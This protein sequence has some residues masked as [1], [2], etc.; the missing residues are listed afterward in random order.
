MTSWSSKTKPTPGNIRHRVEAGQSAINGAMDLVK[1][2][3]KAQ[4]PTD[5]GLT[6]DER[7]MLAALD[8]AYRWLV[9]AN[10]RTRR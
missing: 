10:R 9:D 6:A 1:A 8:N 4:R 5:P 3:S 7:A 2:R